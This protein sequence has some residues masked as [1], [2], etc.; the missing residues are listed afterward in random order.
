MCVNVN[1]ITEERNELEN[2]HL[3]YG[4][5]TKTVDLYEILSQTRQLEVCLLVCLSVH[6]LTQKPNGIE[7]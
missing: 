3:E 6:I 4:L 2:W 7:F 5:Q 1:V